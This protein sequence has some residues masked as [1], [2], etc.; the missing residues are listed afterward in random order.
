VSEGYLSE[1]PN[2]GTV[3]IR[4]SDAPYPIMRL[5][6]PSE[7]SDLLSMD[8]SNTPDRT[9]RSYDGSLLDAILPI[10][11]NLVEAACRDPGSRIGSDFFREHVLVVE[12]FCRQLAPLFG[13]DLGI[14]LPAAILHDISA[15]EDFSKVAEHHTLG[16]IRTADILRDHGFSEEQAVE[17][18][19][20]AQLHLVPVPSGTYGPEAACLSHADALSQMARPAYWLHYAGK[21]RGLGFDEGRGWYRSLVEDRWSRLTDSV[22]P[23]A[24]PLYR[25]AVDACEAR[26]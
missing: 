13:A 10:L 20:C 4:F 15:I 5:A 8:I 22:K 17:V 21:V 25:K 23:V 19:A 6:F 9:I 16:A 2:R 14:V 24:E 12:D 7:M 18:S 3:A 26:Q 11:R 1:G